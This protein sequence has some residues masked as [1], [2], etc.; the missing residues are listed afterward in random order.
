MNEEGIQCFVLARKEIENYAL[1]TA[2]LTKSIRSRQEERIAPTLFLSE[3]EIVGIIDQ[4]SD[5]LKHDT[6]GQLVGHRIKFLQSIGSPKDAATISTEVS[7]EFQTFWPDLDRRLRIISGKDFISAL[8]TRLQQ[9][10]GFSVTVNM[11][12]DALRSDEIEK[13][14]SDIVFGLND[15][16]SIT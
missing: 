4:V 8:S 11:I 7:I 13:D 3:D 10:K 15:F 5:E 14:L 12:I 16:C 6:F 2:A 9:S 1:T